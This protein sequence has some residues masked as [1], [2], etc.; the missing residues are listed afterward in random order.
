MAAGDEAI[1]VAGLGQGSVSARLIWLSDGH[2][3]DL[4]APS[5]WA[6]TAVDGS[7]VALAFA[8]FSAKQLGSRASAEA[9]VRC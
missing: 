4:P 9:S 7:A 2:A 6:P 8:A 1:V 3:V 5:D